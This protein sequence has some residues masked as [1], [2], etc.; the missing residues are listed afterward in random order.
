VEILRFAE[1]SL[2]SSE[3]SVLTFCLTSLRPCYIPS[4][5]LDRDGGWRRIYAWFM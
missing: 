1:E 4:T 5:N 3:D 2:V